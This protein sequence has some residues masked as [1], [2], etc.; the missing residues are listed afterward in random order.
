MKTLLL[1]VAFWLCLDISYGVVFDP[2]SRRYN[3]RNASFDALFSPST[4][5][6]VGIQSLINTATAVD[7]ERCKSIHQFAVR[8]TLDNLVTFHYEL[9]ELCP[10][11]YEAIRYR[12]ISSWGP[13]EE[14][15]QIWYMRFVGALWK[16]IATKTSN[17]RCMLYDALID[18]AEN[19]LDTTLSQFLQN[20]YIPAL[21]QVNDETMNKWRVFIS[22][23]LQFKNRKTKFLKTGGFSISIIQEIAKA[24]LGD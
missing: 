5:A 7:N 11:M 23:N 21:C 12:N 15:M 14:F 13:V 3:L 2:Y 18:A 4:T 20:N 17:D 1:A 10:K 16:M 19:D 8:P 9:T 6:T 22:S 24:Y